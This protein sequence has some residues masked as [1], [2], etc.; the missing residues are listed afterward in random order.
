[1]DNRGLTKTCVFRHVYTSPGVY[2]QIPVAGKLKDFYETFGSLHLYHHAP[3]DCSAIYIGE[4]KE[5]A[6]FA[7]RFA[8]W[9]DILDEYERAE[10]L[11]EWIDNCVVIGEVPYSGNYLLM[12]TLGEHAGYIFEFEHDG[13][14]FIEEAQDIEAYIEAMLNPDGARLVNMAGHMRF[15]EEDPLDQWW[16]LDMKDNRGGFVTTRPDYY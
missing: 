16:I 5:W 15:I 4:P 13:F 3:S 10:L 2:E 6:E 8:G 11:P 12:P 14:E 1:M 9:V 7:D